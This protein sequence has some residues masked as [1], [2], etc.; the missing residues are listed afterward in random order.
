VWD[1]ATG[2]E[3]LSL[4]GHTGYV[5]CVAYSPDGTRIV[6]GSSDHTLKV[7]DA[8]TGQEVLSLKRHTRCIHSLA[9]SPD[10]QRLFA[11]DDQGKVLAWSAKTGKPVEPLAPP[12][13]PPPGPARSPDGFLRAEPRGFTIAITDT[14]LPPNDNT[15]P[16]PDREQRQ[17][18]HR[19]QARLAEAHKQWFAA[20]FHLGRLLRDSP[21][22]AKLKRRR[23]EA[24]KKFKAASAGKDS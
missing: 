15:W 13:K 22:D 1:A 14:R 17:R 23:D 5:Y 8:A 18:Y 12:A 10:G 9:W 3:V 20:A 24:L 6:S 16:L 21:D 2:Q 7:W 4:T 19:E 11:W